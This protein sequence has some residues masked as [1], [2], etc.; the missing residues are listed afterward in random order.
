MDDVSHAIAVDDSG[1]I[2]VGGGSDNPTTGYF[3][4]IAIKYG[5]AL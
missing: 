4:F 5:R 3:D 2:Y 1:N